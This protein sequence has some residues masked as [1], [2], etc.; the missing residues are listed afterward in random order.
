ML[1]RLG[2][3]LLL[4]FGKRILVHLC[5]VPKAKFARSGAFRFDF[6][7]RFTCIFHFVTR[8]LQV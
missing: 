8:A 6:A 7:G 4:E 3:C 5:K 2:C 1:L